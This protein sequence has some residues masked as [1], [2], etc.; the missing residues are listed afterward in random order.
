MHCPYLQHTD[1][2]CS[3]A[4]TNY[5]PSELKWMNFAPPNSICGAR[6]TG[7]IFFMPSACF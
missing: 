1:N 7:S 5:R 3:A 4:G 6:S 2:S